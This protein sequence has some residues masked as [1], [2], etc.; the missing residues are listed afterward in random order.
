MNKKK[1]IEEYSPQYCLSL[2]AAYGANMM[3]EGG[4]EANAK[5]FAG[6]DINNRTILDIGSGLGGLAFYLTDRYSAKVTGVEIN[7][8]LAQEA[9]RRAKKYANDN[10]PNFI[11]LESETKLPFADNSFDIVCSRGVL[12]HLK[13]KDKLFHEINRVL[14]PKGSIALLDWLSPKHGFWSERV[15]RMAEP[16]ENAEDSMVLFAD[17]LESYHQLF[18]STGFVDVI[19]SN[20][21]A[22][23]AKYNQEIA[24]K[25]R[26]QKFTDS[27]IK[28]FGLSLFQ[29][30][31]GYGLIAEAMLKGE[32][33][34]IYFQARKA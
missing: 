28:K 11:A 34:A 20:E 10:A 2:E 9:N 31:E 12:M 14:K 13:E 5:M 17:T 24:D 3:S 26:C 27:F 15:M 1:L 22:S 19:A 21:S 18:A 25:F 4:D 29:Y 7:P 30:V 16:T 6:I 23:H 33:L 8:W 32:M